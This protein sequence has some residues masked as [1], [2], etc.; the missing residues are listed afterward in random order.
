MLF[1]EENPVLT[2]N[3]LDFVLYSFEWCTLAYRLYHTMFRAAGI[4]VGSWMVGMFSKVC[5]IAG[6][7]V[8]QA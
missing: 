7:L 5:W 8:H 3:D 6:H 1:L 4:R 2:E